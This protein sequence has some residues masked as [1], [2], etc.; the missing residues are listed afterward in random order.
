MDPSADP[1]ELFLG[2]IPKPRMTFRGTR[3]HVKLVR[4]ISVKFSKKILSFV[5]VRMDVDA[6]DRRQVPLREMLSIQ[7]ALA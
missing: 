6:L 3:R 5:I 4:E 1:L 2:S 7:V